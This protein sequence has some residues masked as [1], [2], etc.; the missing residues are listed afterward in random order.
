[1]CIRDSDCRLLLDDLGDGDLDPSVPVTCHLGMCLFGDAVMAER[2]LRCNSGGSF[3]GNACRIELATPEGVNRFCA[4]R[5]LV[6]DDACDAPD[7]GTAGC[8]DDLDCLRSQE[9]EQ[10]LT[11]C[12]PEGRCEFPAAA[13]LQEH[14]IDCNHPE[15]R[16]YYFGEPR[17]TPADPGPNDI[18][19]YGEPLPNGLCPV[20]T[21]PVD[22]TFG[23][24]NCPTERNEDQ[25]DH[26]RDGIGDECDDC[27]FGDDD[28][29]TV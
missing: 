21:G 12:S 17:C 9:S 2:G 28:N 11:I 24:D 3:L 22:C 8:R 6:G 5:A 23:P 15:L 26:D 19:G 7:G 10:G 1:M 16:F 20:N 18:C 13:L 4:P 14:G 25:L 29:D 27:A